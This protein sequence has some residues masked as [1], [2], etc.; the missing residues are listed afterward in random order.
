MHHTPSQWLACGLHEETEKA[1]RE[2]I[3]L[4]QAAFLT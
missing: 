2:A 4:V 1:Q 3:D